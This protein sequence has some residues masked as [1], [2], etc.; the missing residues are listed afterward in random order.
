M[1]LTDKGAEELHDIFM[2]FSGIMDG[3]LSELD[4]IIMTEDGE[5]TT[6]FDSLI[7]LMRETIDNFEDDSVDVYDSEFIDENQDF[8]DEEEFED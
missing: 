3:Y 4:K 8:I 6:T 1:A 7:N 5:D 2:S